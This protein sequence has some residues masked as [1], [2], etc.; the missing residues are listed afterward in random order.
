M[1]PFCLGKKKQF[2]FSESNIEAPVQRNSECCMSFSFAKY[3]KQ[4]L[5]AT[6]GT[7]TH[8]DK[9]VIVYIIEFFM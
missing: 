7:E 1:P 6:T 3:L 4:K 9:Q 2:S 5:F 8:A